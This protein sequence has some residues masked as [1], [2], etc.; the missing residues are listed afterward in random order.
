MG[1][2]CRSVGHLQ[3]THCFPTSFFLAF[4]LIETIFVEFQTDSIAN[5]ENLTP[6]LSLKWLPTFEK[7]QVQIR[8][9]IYSS[10]SPPSYDIIIV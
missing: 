10:S 6:T 1:R 8:I 5:V 7:I 4:W 9:Q 2:K 3:F